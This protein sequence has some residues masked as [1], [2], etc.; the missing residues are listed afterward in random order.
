M[1]S[2]FHENARRYAALGL[3]V[4]PLQPKGKEPVTAAGCKQAT[5]DLIVIDRWWSQAPDMNIGIASGSISGLFVVD[6]DGEAGEATVRE[7]ERA[8]G[9]LP[10]TVEAITGKGRH[11]YFRLSDGELIRNSAGKIGPGIDI[12]GDGGYVVA[13]P[14]VH[15]SGRRYEWS[16]DSA[17][18]FGDAPDWLIQKLEKAESG[19]GRPLEEWHAVLTQPIPNGQRNTTLAEIAGKLLFHDVNLVLISDIMACV[20]SARCDPPVEPLEVKAIVASVARTHLRKV[21]ANG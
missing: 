9:S 12:R 19:K 3:S 17:S 15:P 2:E 5:T 20:N 4:F 13:P 16:V 1:R 6:I 7:L 11:C 14:S 10:A 8:N 21:H 18:E